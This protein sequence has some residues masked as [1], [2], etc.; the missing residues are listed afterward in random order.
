[1][2]TMTNVRRPPW[3]SGRNNLALAAAIAFGATVLFGLQRNAYAY[4]PRALPPAIVSQVPHIH[5]LGHGKREVWGFKVYHATLWVSGRSW[6]ASDP[7]AVELEPARTIPA[8]TLID[9]ALEE[10]HDLN[11]GNKARLKVWRREMQEIVPSVKQGDDFVIFC[12][13]SGKTLVYLDGHQK[14][15]VDDTTLCP[16]IMSIWLHPAS[17]QQE[18]RRALLSQ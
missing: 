11:L 12:P 9:A 6:N 13:V 5:P 17:S 14:G 8:A 7:H 3:V 18:L 2:T 10:M 15:E 4:K 1:V 16:A